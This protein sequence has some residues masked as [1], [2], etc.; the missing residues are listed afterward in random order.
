GL[1]MTRAAAYRLA[2]QYH[3]AS[4]KSSRLFILDNQMNDCP[5]RI[6]HDKS[7]GLSVSSP[8]PCSLEEIFEAFYFGQSDE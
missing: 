8:I 5:R 6:I 4:K 1:S 3:V 7:G 2:P